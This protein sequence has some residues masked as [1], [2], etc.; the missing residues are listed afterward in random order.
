[1]KR[2]LSLA[3]RLTLFIGTVLSLLLLCFGWWVERSIDAHFVQQDIDELNAI[4]QS[5]QATL[6]QTS[7]ID[8]AELLTQRFS[9][10]ISGHHSA[11][12]LIMDANG[13]TIYTTPTSRL[14]PLTRAFPTTPSISDNSVH[15]WQHEGKSYRAAVI[16]TNSNFATPMAPFTIA[17]AIDIDF[18]LQFLQDFYRYLRWLTLLACLLAIGATWIAIYQGHAP[19]RRI[20]RQMNA[21]TSE[22]LNFRLN[23]N[24][25]PRELVPLATAFNAMIDRLETGFQ[26]LSN[27]SGDIAHELRT[28]I[29]NLTTQTQ[30]ALSKARTAGEYREVLYSNLEEYDRMSRM[31]G[32]MLFLA[33]ADNQLIEPERQTICIANELRELR[34]FF[35]PWAEEHEVT[36]EVHGEP[37]AIGGDRSMLRRAFSNLVSNAIRHTPSG[38]S[39][40]IQI[41]ENR[42]HVVVSISN[43]GPTIAAN[44]L[45]HIFKRFYRPDASRQRNGEG[46]GLG[47][48]ITQAII[49]AHGGEV[50]SKSEE[51]LTTFEVY[52]KRSINQ[53]CPK[54]NKLVA[55]N[56]ST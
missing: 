2:P 29:T 51:G 5:I 1:M 23:N 41:R 20:S 9:D 37:C 12:F 35:E 52:L 56:S 10:A 21:I 42:S 48:A 40:K 7:S 15:L 38:Q 33:K 24:D 26:Q 11:E 30:V 49:K 8:A 22:R 4:N 16:Q 55:S 36:I 19:I 18:H 17:L 27:F 31:I 50:Q 25:V 39:V 54:S 45:P 47:L 32:D 28:P 43:P 6:A 34:E 14:K 46:A 3:L 44:H 13:N 53:D